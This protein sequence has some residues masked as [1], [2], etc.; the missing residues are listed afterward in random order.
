MN[1]GQIDAPPQPTQEKLP[2]ESPALLGLNGL[3]F[4]EGR[5]KNFKLS[6]NAC[7][8]V[9]FQKMFCRVYC[10]FCLSVTKMI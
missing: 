3:Y 1:G 8:G 10:Y 6:P 9:R 7:F 2:S 5:S 4:V